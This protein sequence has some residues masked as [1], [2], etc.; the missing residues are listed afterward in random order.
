MEDKNYNGVQ[1]SGESPIQ[2][3]VVKLLDGAG[4]PAKDADGKCSSQYDDR[5]YG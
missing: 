5:C 4:Q 1:D 2:G 3:V